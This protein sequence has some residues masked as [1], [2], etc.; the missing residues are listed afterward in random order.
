M[1]HTEIA[2][3]VG[4][5]AVVGLIYAAVKME[6]FGAVQP[7]YGVA[8]GS[9][10]QDVHPDEEGDHF[11]RPETVGGPV[12]NTRH[13]YPSRAGHEISTLIEQGF[14]ALSRPRPQDYDW[15]AYPPSEV[16]L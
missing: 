11:C 9:I 4:A 14:P 5:V 8:V 6:P 2:F 16:T 12:V 3:C 1:K 10:Y 15:Y 13:R 7:E